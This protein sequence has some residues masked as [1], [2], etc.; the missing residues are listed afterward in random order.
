TAAGREAE[1]RKV[2]Q[3]LQGD[4][5][6]I[7]LT[8]MRKDP[9]RRYSSAQAFAD[10]IRRHLDRLP[11]LARSDGA[12]YRLSKWVARHKAGSA[13]AA[14]VVM[15]AGILGWQTYEAKAPAERAA[16]RMKA[17]PS[18]AVLGFKN[19]S[20]RP[21]SAW[22]STALTEML[23]AELAAGEQ[24]RTVPGE[25]VATVKLELSLAEADSFGRDTLTRL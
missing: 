16:A 6:S 22:M 17:R 13:A 2:R 25:R 18:I 5:D 9:E 14:A 7:V 4:L 8:A 15:V 24:L 12:G 1:T 23:G 10:D 19:L 21:E 20:G 11:V 3:A